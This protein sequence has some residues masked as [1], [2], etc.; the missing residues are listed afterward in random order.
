MNL[1]VDARRPSLFAIDPRLGGRIVR[2]ASPVIIGMLVQTTINVV[3]TIM[4]GHLPPAQATPGQAALE[5]SLLLLWFLGGFLGAI[6]VGTQALTARR[7]GEGDDARASQVLTN[8][9]VIAFLSSVVLTA[10]AWLAT[11]WLFRLVNHHPQVIAVGLPYWR[12]RLIGMLS[13]VGTLAVKSFFDGIGQTKVHMT[14]SVLMNVVNIVLAYGLIFGH[15]G[16]PRLEVEGAGIAAAVSSYVGF[17]LMLGALLLPRFRRRFHYLRLSNLSRRVAGDIVRLSLPSGIA[18]MVVMTGFG[19]FYRIVG[20][21]DLLRGGGGTVNFTATS[22]IIRILSLLFIAA[23]GYG[24][25]TA[26]LVSQSMGEKKP[27]L[28]ER[29]GWEAVR[30][31]AYAG[32]VLALVTVVFATPILEIF[33]RDAAVIAAALPALRLAGVF[34]PMMVAAL[35]FTQAHFGAGNARLVMTLEV[36]LH[37]GCLVPLTWVLGVWL[38]LG[39]LGVWSAAMTYIL[40]LALILGWKFGQGKW[41]E[42]VI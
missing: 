3:D 7:I 24:T 38:A 2:L 33:T 20:E 15:L 32:A 37:F 6:S 42:I 5:V 35:V 34:E 19:L 26:T 28:A 30:I 8:S 1:P 14:V 27:D 10:A 4:V 22:I 40:L 39:M 9:I 25:A 31:G 17:F 36:A 18:T 23:L 11:P 29:Y 12:W 13:M 21:T 16:M 41:K